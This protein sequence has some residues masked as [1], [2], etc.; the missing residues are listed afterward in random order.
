M[1]MIGIPRSVV[2]DNFD[3]AWALLSPNKAQTPL[4]VDA[5]AVLPS[6][7]PQQG[8]Q[9]ITRGG[10][11]RFQGR[12]CLQLRQLAFCHSFDAGKAPALPADEQMLGISAFEMDDGHDRSLY[13]LPISG[14]HFQK[15]SKMAWPTAV[16][17]A[18]TW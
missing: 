11:Q 16:L 9:P 7:A 12:R 17:L 13:R 6:S 14:K 3:L 2:I 4:V 15:F 8:F 1:F 5:N 10:S 18:G